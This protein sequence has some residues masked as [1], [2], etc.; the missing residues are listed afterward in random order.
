MMLQ[1]SSLLDFP[2]NATK[3]GELISDCLFNKLT[4]FNSF[5]GM[6]STGFDKE[7]SPFLRKMKARKGCGVKV[8][9]G[10]KEETFLIILL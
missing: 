8:S 2:R 9:E 4:D 10:R 6:P 7:I 5:V 3:G 1:A